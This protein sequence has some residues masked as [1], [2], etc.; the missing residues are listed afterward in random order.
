MSYVNDV[1][2]ENL[3]DE[4]LDEKP[5]FVSDVLYGI[6]QALFLLMH[7]SELLAGYELSSS[8]FRDVN[9]LLTTISYFRII[10]IYC[11]LSKN[12]RYYGTRIS[13]LLSV[14][15]HRSKATNFMYAIKCLFK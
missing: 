13:R 7:P 10:F 5:V 2:V 11:Y 1:K 8:M 15:G 14:Y 9:T 6:S 3:S 4:D 12:T